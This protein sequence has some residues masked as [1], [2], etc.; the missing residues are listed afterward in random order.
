MTLQEL[1]L[2]LNASE[3]LRIN[4]HDSSGLFTTAPFGLDFPLRIHA[5]PFC[6][7][8]KS[9]PRGYSLCTACKVTVCRRAIRRGTPTF[10]ICPYGLCELVYPIF[11]EG[12][13]LCILFLGNCVEDKEINRAK[14]LSTC[15]QTGVTPEPMLAC[16]D[17]LPPADRK[18]MMDTARLVEAYIR[19]LIETTPTRLAAKPT[20]HWVVQGMLDYTQKHLQRPLTLKELAGLYAMNETYL[21]KLFREQT[22]QRF[23][24]YLTNLRLSRAAALLRAT[25]RPVLEIALESGFP[26][27][28]YFNRS[29]SARYGMTPTVYRQGSNG[30]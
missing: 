1:F 2:F 4:L 13:P 6:D 21:G 18:R 10:G 23:H 19:M 11:R 24:T 26:S 5:Q 17:S 30:S 9:T 8:A 12:K 3:K 29:F 16:L 22:G 7:L 15:K 25:D 20:Y 28:S 27:I 14:L